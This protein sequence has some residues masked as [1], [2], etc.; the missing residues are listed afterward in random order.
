M[1]TSVAATL[2]ASNA[3]AANTT[4]NQRLVVREAAEPDLP[5]LEIGWERIYF[6]VASIALSM[7]TMQPFMSFLAIMSWAIRISFMA[8]VLASPSPMA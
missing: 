1:W 4:I 5:S 7:W 2:A 8:V 3:P 6:S